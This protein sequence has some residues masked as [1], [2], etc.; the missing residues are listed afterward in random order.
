MSS[1]T[2]SLKELHQKQKEFEQVDE[3]TKLLADMFDKDEAQGVI[4]FE[5][6]YIIDTISMDEFTVKLNTLK[7]FELTTE[8]SH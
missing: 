4:K 1:D 3:L 2:L 7:V 5:D 8:R 6:I